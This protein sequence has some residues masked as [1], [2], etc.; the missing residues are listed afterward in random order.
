MSI[1]S[2]SERGSSLIKKE[3][4]AFKSGDF[5]RRRLIEGRLLF[6]GIRYIYILSPT[7]KA[8][9]SA[10]VKA[11]ERSINNPVS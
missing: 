11:P 2:A 1:S 8:P 10:T 9:S 4:M 3:K 5:S 6:Q 7:P